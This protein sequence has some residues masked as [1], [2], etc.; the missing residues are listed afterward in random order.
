MKVLPFLLVL[1]LCG[2]EPKFHTGKVWKKEYVPAQI[3][4]MTQCVSNG[5]TVTTIQVPQY[6]PERYEVTLVNEKGQVEFE[7]FT[8]DA[9]TFHKL[10]LGDKTTL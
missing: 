10:N 2:C 4:L 6:F 5:K 7:T 9:I 3:I 1:L 8:V